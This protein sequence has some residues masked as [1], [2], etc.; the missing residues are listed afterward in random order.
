MSTGRVTMDRQL[1]DWALHREKEVFTD[2][3]GTMIQQVA[4]LDLKKNP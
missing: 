3:L 4:K 2:K 1:N